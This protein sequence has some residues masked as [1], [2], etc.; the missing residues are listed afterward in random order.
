[1]SLQIATSK[2]DAITIFT[3]QGAFA[4]ADDAEALLRAARQTLD[5]DAPQIILDLA[6]ISHLE[7]TG[8]S[9]VVKI[10]TATTEKGGKVKLLHLSPRVQNI[11][12]ITKLISYF[13]VYNDL[14]E[15][16]ASFKT[17]RK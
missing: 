6:G 10:L 12:H 16:I 7:S 17:Q 8:L 15:A 14:Q 2:E 1:M 9:A 13:E 3:L 5:A 4:T 11:L